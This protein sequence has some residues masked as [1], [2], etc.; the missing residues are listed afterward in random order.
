MTSTIATEL[1]RIQSLTVKS[2]L[3]Y[4]ADGVSSARV[5]EI[6]SVAYLLRGSVQ[7]Q[8][9]RVRVVAELIDGETSA[10]RWSECYDRNGDDVLDIQDDIARAIVATL[11]GYHGRLQQVEL[12]HS[13]AKATRDFNAFDYVLRGIQY[14][15]R[16]TRE[17]NI[18]AYEYFSKAHEL[19]PEYADALAWMA[20]I[21]VMDVYLQLAQNPK[22]SLEQAFE[23]ANKAL[24]LDRFSEIGTWVLGSAYIASGQSELGL[25]TI[26]RA[27]EINP[28]NPDILVEKGEALS[29]NGRA[30][31]G[32]E[33]ILQ[34]IELNPFHPEWYF[35]SL[36]VACY[37][38]KKYAEAIEA[39]DQITNHNINT[40]L[41]QAASH[42]RL[43][44]QEEAKA[45]AYQVIELDP[46]FSLGT[47]LFE[48]QATDNLSI[49]KH[50]LEGLRLAGL[51]E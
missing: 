33:C 47:T 5:A 30:E 40:R 17:D 9:D 50:L 39:L 19:N 2:A 24:E 4:E 21:H 14:K 11:W 44:H 42:A 22:N 48:I 35:W 13:V 46:A 37:L 6:W 1:S 41:Y 31:E 8:G 45:H 38:A 51:P 3:T 34:S 36:G 43:G 25:A 7:K 29:W 26:D 20:W 49:Y 10:I 23:L 12:E 15:E 18:K 16:F 27:L 28:N 32:V